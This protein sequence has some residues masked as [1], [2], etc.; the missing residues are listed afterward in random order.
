[1]SK[2]YSQDV[3]GKYRSIKNYVSFV[4]LLIYFI[5]PWLRWDRGAGIPDQMILIDL[6]MRRGY[7]FNIEIW[8]EELYY[9][10]AILVLAALGLFF[11]TSMLGRVWC[12]YTCPHT[13]FVDLFIKIENIFQG[14]RNARIKL[15]AEYFNSRKFFKK[16]ATHF[17]WLILSWFFAFGW[18]CYFYNAPDFLNHL[19]HNRLGAE[20]ISWMLGLTLSTY[21]FAGFMREKV[22]VYICPYG[23]FQSAM[24]D[25]ST[26]VVYYD[27]LRG[28]PRRDQD[29][30]SEGNIEGDCID[31]NRCV[32]V[33][34]MG[35][36]IRDGLQMSCIS[37]GLC[38]DACD[39]VMNRI[40]KPTGLI[41]YNSLNKSRAIES[42][43]FKFI[44]YKA[45]C[46]GVLFLIVICIVIYNLNNKMSFSTTVEK[47]RNDMFTIMP[48]GRVRNS[49]V[50]SINNKELKSESFCI[51]VMSHSY[52]G[53]K[54]QSYNN[55]TNSVHYQSEDCLLISPDSRIS[56]TMFVR[57]NNFGKLNNSSEKISFRICKQ[58]VNQCI[59]IS[60]LFIYND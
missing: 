3:R 31:C 17:S 14:D 4:L 53:I 12:G 28:E 36:D 15:D 27:E 46:Y 16:T 44:R 42:N 30:R 25:M 59:N 33:C 49:Y 50:L 39:S 38:I 7:F 54:V 40:G 13:V 10:T 24:I 56:Y 29:H 48:D 2:I 18:I 26:K 8:P 32:A 11:V 35:I 1:M 45:L 60:S 23:R 34:P 6:P 9:V 22:C 58:S 5:I 19:I 21:F 37:C 51:M 52:Y 20:S 55:L 43:K 41:T 57:N 47:D